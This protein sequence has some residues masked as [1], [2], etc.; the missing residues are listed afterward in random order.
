MTRTW[1]PTFRTTLLY[2]C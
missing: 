1:R 2:E